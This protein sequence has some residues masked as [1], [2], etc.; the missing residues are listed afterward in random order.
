MCDYKD[1]DMQKKCEGYEKEQERYVFWNTTVSDNCC[2]YCNNTVYKADT[3]IDTNKLGDKCDSEESFVCR[4]IPGLEAKIETE[5]RYGKCCNDDVGL[6]G[7]NSTEL[8]PATCSERKCIRPVNAPYA[9]WISE[10]YIDPKS[11]EEI[12]GC[13][14]C[15]INDEKLGKI[16][17]ADK[18]VFIM[19]G[20][21]FEC[22]RG[23]V[24]KKVKEVTKTG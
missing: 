23:E 18:A 3:V 12:E 17:V 22:C 24:V 15:E 9:V 5:F 19:G 14:C 8:Q 1:P 11:G 10:T 4:Y 21:E 6:Q 7:L 16:L 13:D 2:L 20:E